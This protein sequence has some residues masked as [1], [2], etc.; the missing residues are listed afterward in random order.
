MFNKIISKK[1]RPR[2]LS[3]DNDPLFQYHRWHANLRILEIEEIKSLPY[4]PM[5]HPFVERLVKI[6][7]N[8][9]LD[10]SLFWTDSD[11]QSKLDK[12]QQYFNEHRAHMGLDGQIPSQIS[13]NK[14][15]KPIDIN[16]FRWKLHCK[17]LFQ[18]PIAA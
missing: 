16:H 7:R 18:L 12:F 2:Y 11:L 8:E 9:L 3:S 15:S 5:S 10:R 13:N 1:Q 17:G 6:V 4:I 14:K